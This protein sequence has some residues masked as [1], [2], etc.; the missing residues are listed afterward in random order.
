MTSTRHMASCFIRHRLRILIAVV[1][2]SIC[3]D[4]ANCAPSISN[5]AAD[6]T[7]NCGIYREEEGFLLNMLP[8]DASEKSVSAENSDD[9]LPDTEGTAISSIQR[10]T[11]SSST[12]NYNAKASVGYALRISDVNKF[13]IRAGYA[14]AAEHIGYDLLK[15]IKKKIKA[16]AYP[17][18]M[19]YWERKGILFMQNMSMNLGLLVT[20]ERKMGKQDFPIVRAVA[21][22]KYRMGDLTNIYTGLQAETYP[23]MIG[24]EQSMRNNLSL[25]M[26]IELSL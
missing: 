24:D 13:V 1:V 8:R 10:F 23:K 25:V 3:V 22:L 26:G 6:M 7:F 20:D 19:L 14:Y 18:T 5:L 4:N 2:T 9:D 15:N 16:H 21:G 11:K 17:Y 12:V